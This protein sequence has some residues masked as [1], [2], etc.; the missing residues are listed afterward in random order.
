MGLVHW[1]H[2]QQHGRHFLWAISACGL[3]S[4]EVQFLKTPFKPRHFRS[5]PR[6]DPE[7]C[8]VFRGCQ[9]VGLPFF[10]SLHPGPPKEKEQHKLDVHWVLQIHIR[11]AEDYRR[12]GVISSLLLRRRGNRASKPSGRSGSEPSL[13]APREEWP[14]GPG[15]SLKKDTSL[16]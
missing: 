16:R 14:L 6:A 13:S 2:R 9:R 12:L 5:Q 11:R 10:L 8:S 15:K 4:I 3:L 7:A 1:W